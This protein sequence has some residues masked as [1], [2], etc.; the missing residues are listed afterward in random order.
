M[1]EFK[2]WIGDVDIGMR[3]NGWF[4]RINGCNVFD[5]VNEYG[6]KGLK[7][8]SIAERLASKEQAEQ[9]ALA[10][11]SKQ[12]CKRGIDATLA[13][14]DQRIA[15]L[16]KLLRESR[17]WVAYAHF[18]DFEGTEDLGLRIDAALPASDSGEV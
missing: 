14:K 5:T 3:G 8:F 9:A 6:C 13:A 17:R 15:E 2:D 7:T 4:V 16:E 1:A 18:E 10:W 11:I 12:S